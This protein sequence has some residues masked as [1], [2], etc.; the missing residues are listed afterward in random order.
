MARRKWN[1]ETIQQVVD[2]ENP[3]I[4]VGYTAASAERKEGEIWED[5][6]G[7][8]FQR[9]KGRDVQIDSKNTPILDAINSASKC[10]VCGM[11][12]RN[13][14]NKLDRKVFAKTNKCYECLELEE[15]TYRTNGK[16][17]QY[18]KMKVLKNHRAALRDFKDKVLESIQFLES[19]TGKIR[20][21][22][23]DGTEITFSGKSNPQWLIDAREDL[24]KVTTELEKIETEI[25]AF[26]EELKV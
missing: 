21:S 2:G 22:L 9:K 1:L 4:Q 3:F 16:W 10:S 7:R 17:E 11:N 25:T 6:S 20:E 19:E 14:G 26:E 15:M 23:P 18:E 5:K 13:Y 24:E 8:K 12:V